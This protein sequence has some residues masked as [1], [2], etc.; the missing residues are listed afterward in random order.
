M[1][2]VKKLPD[3]DI[4]FSNV[5]SVGNETKSRKIEHVKV[6]L[7]VD[8]QY[9]LLTTMFNDVTLLPNGKEVDIDT[10]KTEAKF[11]R[12][13]ITA[14]IFVSG[15]TGGD[16]R[17][18]KINYDIA[19][20]VSELK[21]PMGVG[22]QR[23]MIEDK[24]VVETYAVKREYDVILLGNIGAAQ[25]INYKVEQIVDMLSKI[26]A[27]ALCIH[28]NPAQEIAQPEG[29]IKFKGALEAIERLADNLDQKVIVKEV[30]NGISKEV[31]KRLA[32]TNIYGMDTGGAGGTNWVAIE[33]Y[34]AGKSG[35]YKHIFKEWGLSTAQSLL[36]IKSEFNGF[37]TATGGI[38][39]GLDLVKAVVLGADACGI[40]TPIIQAQ[41]T[42]G[43][44]GIK[45]YLNN[46]IYDFKLEM[47][48]LGVSDIQEL[49]G[50]KYNLSGSLY[51]IVQQRL[52][53]KPL[54]EYL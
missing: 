47:A 6:A 46:L 49:K 24:N 4:E 3:E 7:N 38:R 8:V 53:N 21:L 54:V 33:L 35:E 12:K 18:G 51:R 25:A 16:Q 28:T 48:K 42:G 37:V 52:Y 14:P 45:S 5:Q 2:K 9:K 15:M 36:E 20:A 44:D 22:S 17:V 27:D 11:L 29:D 19:R 50:I 13:N 31:A 41:S 1:E 43:S 23:A 30:G 10:I 40:A 39:T 26:D 34:R 32:Q